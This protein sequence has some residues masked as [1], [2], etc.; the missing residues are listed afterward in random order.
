MDTNQKKRY[1]VW[2]LG[3]VGKSVLKHLS[4]EGH[5][6][7]VMDKRTPSAEET[8]FLEELTIRYYPETERTHFFE[9][10]DHI[11]PSPGVPLDAMTTYSHKIIEELDLFAAAWKKPLIAVTG[12]IGK[13]SI[14]HMLSAILEH[15]TVSVAT[16][17]NIG[18]GM[19][20]LIDDQHN[21]GYGLLELSSFQLERTR[22]FAPD[23]AVWTNLYPNHL[24]RHGT[25]D[26]YF[27]AKYQ[28]L[29]GQKEHQKALLPLQLISKMREHTSRPLIF[30]SSSASQEAIQ[31]LR[32]LDTLYT[33]RGNT[34]LKMYID[35]YGTK[36]ETIFPNPCKDQL[37]YQE[38]ELILIATCDILG[39]LTRD[40][41]AIPQLTVPAHRLE[42]IEGRNDLT[43]YNDSKSSIFEATLAAVNRL[44]PGR[45]H[46]FLGGISKGVDRTSLIPALKDKVSSITCF[47]GEAENLF[48]ACKKVQIPSTHHETLE[49]AFKFCI[50][51]SQPG[52]TILFSPA[53]ASYDLFKNY[54]ERGNRFK[55]LVQQ[56]RDNL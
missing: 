18:T 39:L 9:C 30:F 4:A 3:V 15:N 8:E 10:N 56:Y 29:I 52:D 32:P 55:E 47:G 14:V 25:F 2:G 46:L 49:D 11:V 28:M 27:L 21:V 5:E 44:Q 20:D 43:F 12:T 42:K 37:S 24:D 16:G 23:V 13:T 48:E 34:I 19:L 45:I 31:Q 41:F 35:A 1:G 51:R 36:H 17:G 53:G 22:S 38:N 6:L 50:G 40:T 54:Q 26:D 7:S 33:F